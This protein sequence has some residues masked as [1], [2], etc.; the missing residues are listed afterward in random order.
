MLGVHVS[1]SMPVL[2]FRLNAKDPP[3]FTITSHTGLAIG[4]TIAVDIF[5]DRA[6]G[7]LQVLRRTRKVISERTTWHRNVIVVLL[8]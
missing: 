7:K 3:V 8:L 5:Q 6:P 4:A 1:L 2:H